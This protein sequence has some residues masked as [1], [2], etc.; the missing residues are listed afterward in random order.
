MAD[1]SAVRSLRYRYIIGLTAIAILVSGSHLLLGQITDKQNNNALV[2]RIAAAQ[3]GLTSR[4]AHFSSLMEAA[5][6]ANEFNE[7]RAQLGRTINQMLSN[8]EILIG[9]DRDA[10]IPILWNKNLE[11]IYY[12]PSVGL[13]L[14]VRRYIERAHTLYDMPFGDVKET[15]SAF[16][17]L[18][19]YGPFVL[20]PIFDAAVT[21]YQRISNQTVERIINLE[22]GVWFAA[23]L[24][25]LLEAMFIFR[26]LE[27][28]MREKIDIITRNTETLSASLKAAEQSKQVAQIERDR[29]LAA[30]R[31][32]A[33][34]L[35]N[36]SHEF[37]TPLNAIIGF[38]DT[39]RA[40]V[41]G[42]FA[43]PRQRER[44]EDIQNSGTHLLSLIN[45]L[46]DLSAAEAGSLELEYE[47][48]SVA[49]LVSSALRYIETAAEE[50]GMRIVVAPYDARA[51]V[52]CD[53]R[54]AIQV[55]LN[56]LSN[57]IKYS[58]EGGT[59]TVS[60]DRA[61]PDFIAIRI[62]DDG[63]G[64]SPEQ[65]KVALARFGRV[66]SSADTSQL[67]TGLG[68][69][70]AADL[71]RL[72]GGTL[73]IRSVPGNGTT[74]SLLFSRD[75]SSEELRSEPTDRADT[76]GDKLLKPRG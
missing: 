52:R 50:R 74:V 58:D 16:V 72:H 33:E 2:I 62:A 63:P 18:V 12:D 34:F 19:S 9:G 36:M 46:L 8:H 31:A 40:G 42:D 75:V 26:P 6:S 43:D 65:I 53:V 68:I 44:I 11:A 38:S 28:R 73:D 71:M 60:V 13:D 41:Y 15:T 51:A 21:E 56:V 25:L 27:R 59:V 64:M 66:K 49:E 69:P 55:L 57:A 32:K 24:A 10:G 17:F 45:D 5:D 70:L 29:A 76:V 20:E 30:D 14:A 48:T 3:A 4:V 39:L 61:D 35:S 37:R 23:L 22:T 7:A 1:F 67:G 54:R 47:P